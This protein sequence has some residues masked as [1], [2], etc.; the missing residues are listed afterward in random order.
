MFR[1]L[2]APQNTR[3]NIL[4]YFMSMKDVLIVVMMALVISCENS[5]EEM[6]KGHVDHAEWYVFSFGLN[7]GGKPY[8]K[9]RIQ[10]SYSY[11]G[12]TYQGKFNNGRSFGPLFKGDS[13]V[14]SVQISDPT[15]H[16]VIGRVDN[17]RIKFKSVSNIDTIDA[18]DAVLIE[19]W[20][21]TR[22][23]EVTVQE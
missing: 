6:V 15:N 20:E 10:F 22:L 23:D 12:K 2:L 5:N 17:R 18:Y 1:R 4:I 13:L 14:L 3:I 9:Q 19:Q 7:G 8:Y 11:R 16:E 21:E